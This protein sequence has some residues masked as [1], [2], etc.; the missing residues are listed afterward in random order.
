MNV[1]V[2]DEAW[3]ATAL[4][5]REHPTQPDFKSADIVRRARREFNDN[6]PGI[7][8]HVVSHCVASNPPSPVRYRMLHETGRGRR[9]LY[10][11]GDP[12]HPDRI[13]KTHPD[14]RDLPPRYHELVDWY[15]REYSHSAKDETQ[16]TNKAEFLLKFVG[17]ISAFDLKKMTE[18]IQDGCERVDHN[19]W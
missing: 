10:R 13:G 19:E 8:A 6:R 14:K 1:K 17:A 15:V 12:V 3:V 18:V 2:A 7:S 9:R 16:R 11:P 5:H 4:L